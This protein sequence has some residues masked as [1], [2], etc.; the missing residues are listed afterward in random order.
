[1]LYISV[2]PSCPLNRLYIERLKHSLQN[3]KQPL[4]FQ[5]IAKAVEEHVWV[6]RSGITDLSEEG[7]KMMGY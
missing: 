1:V 2:G 7:M 5:R 4:D 3:G 6:G